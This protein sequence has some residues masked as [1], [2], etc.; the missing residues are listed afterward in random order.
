MICIHVNANPT[1]VW[2]VEVHTF[3]RLYCE[4]SWMRLLHADS[5]AFWICTSSLCSRLCHT[6]SKS[7]CAILSQV[8]IIPQSCSLATDVYEMNW[9]HG[10]NTFTL[11]NLWMFSVTSIADCGNLAWSKSATKWQQYPHIQHQRPT[12]S[13]SRDCVRNHQFKDSQKSKSDKSNVATGM[14]YGV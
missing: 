2:T 11:I 12:S 10:A 13:V 1:L 7:K 5:I 3:K 6:I 9:V 8:I 14:K 4:F